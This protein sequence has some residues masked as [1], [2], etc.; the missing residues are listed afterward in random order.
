[1]V[2]HLIGYDRLETPEQLSLLNTIYLNL[3]L[4]SNFFQPVLKL[5]YKEHRNYKI[6][7]HYDL[8][9]T[10]FRRVVKSVQST[11]ELKAK[12]AYLYFQLNPVALRNSID[13]DVAILWKI[14]R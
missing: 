8:A 13:N 2:R 1:M 4:F 10:P 6:I 11:F 5:I 9:T 14:A 7:K 3:R 12:L